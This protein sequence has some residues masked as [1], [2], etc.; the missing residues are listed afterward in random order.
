MT[1][2]Q[3]LTDLAIHVVQA[4]L[5]T[6][7]SAAADIR[8]GQDDLIALDKKAKAALSIPAQSFDD[9]ERER[10]QL[11]ISM[12]E[13]GKATGCGHTETPDGWQTMVR[14]VEQSIAGAK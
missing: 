7:C 11:L 1:R 13:I 6:L 10:D 14:C 3:A 12:R 5:P 2:E 4:R 9:I 8:D